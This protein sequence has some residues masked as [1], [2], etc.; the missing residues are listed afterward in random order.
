MSCCF[1]F[2][3]YYENKQK[4]SKVR[5][6]QLARTI[7][8]ITRIIIR[9]LKRISFYLPSS[10]GSPVGSNVVQ[11]PD[12]SGLAAGSDFRIRLEWP[13]SGD[14]DSSLSC[15]SSWWLKQTRC[16]GLSIFRLDWSLGQLCSKLRSMV[17]QASK[18][19]CSVIGHPTFVVSWHSQD[20]LYSTITV[21]HDWHSHDSSTSVAARSWAVAVTMISAGREPSLHLN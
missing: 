10:I 12:C 5:S 7:H 1:T 3:L 6:R 16:F 9:L 14:W 13:P 2:V 17:N 11:A 8:F 18:S 21:H 15:A 4:I 19:Y 20:H